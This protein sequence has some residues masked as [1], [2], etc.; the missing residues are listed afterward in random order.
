MTIFLFGCVDI[1]NPDMI[2]RL[3]TKYCLDGQMLR[4]LQFLQ[5][6]TIFAIVVAW[7]LITSNFCNFISQT[8]PDHSQKPHQHSH[9]KQIHANF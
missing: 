7:D 9:P 4:Y 6:H 3:N 1:E 5:Q 2:L 8:I